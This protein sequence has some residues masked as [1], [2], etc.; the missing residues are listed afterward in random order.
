VGLLLV[1]LPSFVGLKDAVTD[2]GAPQ[3]HAVAPLIEV[4]PTDFCMGTRGDRRDPITANPALTQ[5]L[6]AA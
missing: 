3:T 5:D 4:Q 1:L 2:G 6:Q